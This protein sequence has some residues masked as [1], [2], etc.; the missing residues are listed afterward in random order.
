[1]FSTLRAELSER[2]PNNV[3]HVAW[4]DVDTHAPGLEARHV[5]QIPDKAIQPLRLLAGGCYEILPRGLGQATAIFRQT[6]E[7]A[8]DRCERRAEIVGDGIQ[9]RLLKTIR[10]F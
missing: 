10:F 4:L 5:E 7:R 3:L 1:S 9:E 2:S 6:T 8:C